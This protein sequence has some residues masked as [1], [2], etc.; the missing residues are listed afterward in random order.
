MAGDRTSVFFYD[1]GN[2]QSAYAEVWLL[3]PPEEVRATLRA[4]PRAAPPRAIAVFIG[5]LPAGTNEEVCV[6]VHGI[7][8]ENYEEWFESFAGTADNRIAWDPAAGLELSQTVPGLD[9]A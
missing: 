9:A 3:L 6:E 2:S 8:C 7:P 4:M 5:A 1:L